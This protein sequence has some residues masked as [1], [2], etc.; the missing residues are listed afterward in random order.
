MASQQA[1]KNSELVWV[2]KCPCAF[3]K[4]RILDLLDEILFKLYVFYHNISITLFFVSFQVSLFFEDELQAFPTNEGNCIG[5][6]FSN[7]FQQINNILQT[8]SL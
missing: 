3:W 4:K 6:M 7:Y 8:V 2:L 1:Q 5:F